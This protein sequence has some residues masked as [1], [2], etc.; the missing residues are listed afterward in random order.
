MTDITTPPADPGAELH[1]RLAPLAAAAAG[2]FGPHPVAAAFLALGVTVAVHAH[3]P[4]RAAEWLRDM[5]DELDKGALR[6]GPRPC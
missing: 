2:A 4:T 3:G 5:A 6:A 1:A